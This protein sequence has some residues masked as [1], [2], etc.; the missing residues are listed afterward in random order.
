MAL[1]KINEKN[2]AFIFINAM[3]ANICVKSLI[4]S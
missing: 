1:M 4:G 2:H 3:S